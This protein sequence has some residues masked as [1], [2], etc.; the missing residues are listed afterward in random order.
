MTEI[1][2]M[3]EIIILLVLIALTNSRVTEA[4]NLITVL[5]G[6]VEIA[7]QVLNKMISEAMEEQNGDIGGEDKNENE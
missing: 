7:L 6:D 3:L 4:M 5:Q 1:F 2:V